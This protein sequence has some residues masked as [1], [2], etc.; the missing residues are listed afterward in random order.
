MSGGVFPN[1]SSHKSQYRPGKL[2]IIED[3]LDI[4]KVLRIFLDSK[5]YETLTE[6]NALDLMEICLTEKPDAI[7]LD[8]G[9]PYRDLG[10]VY[11]ELRGD[12][13]TMQIPIVFV[14]PK[15][16]E[17]SEW[18]RVKGLGLNSKDAIVEVSD[19]DGLAKSIEEIWPMIR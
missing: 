18:E 7:I 11:A 16:S 19:Y 10:D 15:D 17:S 2:L 14:I 8:T 1:H 13:R 4:L 6:K 9:L 5:G 12:T 3:H